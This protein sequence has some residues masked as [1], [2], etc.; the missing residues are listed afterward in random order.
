MVTVSQIVNLR[1]PALVVSNYLSDFENFPEWD[2]SAIEATRD[3]EGP[4]GTG[5]RFT[6]LARHFGRTV[7][8]AYEITEYRPAVG[9]VAVGTGR[10]FRVV[11]EVRFTSS[12][13]VT[14]VHWRSSVKLRGVAVV[15]APVLKTA[16]ARIGDSAMDGLRVYFSSLK[17]ERPTRSSRPALAI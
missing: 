4:I 1:A 16:M 9:F 5:T 14:K 11:N 6:V 7:H 13:G 2:R 8:I 17:R 3:S 15:F 12:G 10:G